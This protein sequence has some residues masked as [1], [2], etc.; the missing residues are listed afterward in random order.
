MELCF[1]LLLSV[2]QKPSGN[3]LDIDV[4]ENNHPVFGIPINN[5]K[6]MHPIDFLM[7]KHMNADFDPMVP[8]PSED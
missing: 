5:E 8:P 3:I 7:R 6:R 4:Y 1:E 2:T